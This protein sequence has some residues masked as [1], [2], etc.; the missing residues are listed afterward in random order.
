[1]KEERTHHL[2]FCLSKGQLHHPERE[3][4]PLCCLAFEFCTRK[5]RWN[6]FQEGEL[7]LTSQFMSTSTLECIVF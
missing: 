3:F 1:M 5:P 7:I 2:T 4:P 6:V